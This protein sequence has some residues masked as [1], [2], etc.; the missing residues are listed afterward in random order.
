MPAKQSK[1]FAGEIIS[2][3]QKIK[4]KDV[5]L[6]VLEDVLKKGGYEYVS[7][8]DYTD[9]VPELGNNGGRYSYAVKLYLLENGKYEKYYYT[10][11]DIA[12]F[13][14]ICGNWNSSCCEEDDREVL[15]A[16]GVASLVLS[17]ATSIDEGAEYEINILNKL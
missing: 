5:R 6:N 7:L 14:N 10:S 16:R 8:W 1:N 13:C 3:V 15:T 9:Y 2:S 12:G 4:N 17:Y 11:S